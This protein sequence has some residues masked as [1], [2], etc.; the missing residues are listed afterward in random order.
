MT[1]MGSLLIDRQHHGVGRRSDIETDHVS[2]LGGELRV[3]RP[4]EGAHAV[5][6]QLVCFPDA[7]H[8]AQRETGGLGHRP[9]GPVRRLARRVAAGQRH[10]A[11][12]EFGRDRQ[13]TGLAGL[14]AEQSIHAGLGKALLPAPDRRPADAHQRRGPLHRPSFRGGQH[15]TI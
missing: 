7:L 10:H 15:S 3:A 2:E 13:L 5:R 8:R 14:V 1:P 12:H 6:L 11:S 9:S 4:L